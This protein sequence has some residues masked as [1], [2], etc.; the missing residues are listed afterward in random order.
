MTRLLIAT[1]FV[2]STV[3]AGCGKLGTLEQP[4][5]LFG[6]QAKADYAAKQRAAADAR[7]RAKVKTEAEPDT[8]D[9]DPN[10]RPLA[11]APYAT[12]MPGAPTSPNSPAPPDA[13]GSPGATPNNQ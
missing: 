6:A 10:Y 12:P 11:Q 9:S 3:L 2:A 8:P 1:L 5:P 7:A 4:A 13:L